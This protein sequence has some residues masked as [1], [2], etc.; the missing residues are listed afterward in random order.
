[1]VL[2]DEL[3]RHQDKIFLYNSYIEKLRVKLY[4]E[5]D[6][7]IDNAYQKNENG[8]SIISTE[9]R[10]NKALEIVSLLLKEY[11]EYSD[12]YVELIKK[13][14]NEEQECSDFHNNTQ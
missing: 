12:S 10:L 7:K 9:I 13:E 3:K 2:E 11:Q 6:K 1:M 4:Y 14:Q 8:L 5:R